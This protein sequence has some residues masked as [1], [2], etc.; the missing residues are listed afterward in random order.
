MKK[1]VVL[2]VVLIIL[3]FS[4][5]NANKAQALRICIDIPCFDEYSQNDIENS[6]N[7]FL[8]RIQKN[9]G[10]ENIEIE[11][12]PALGT[13][14]ETE[15]TRMRTEMMS[16]GGPDIF[17]IWMG[18]PDFETVF[19]ITEKSMELGAFLPLDQYIE[20]AQFMEW[21]SMTQEIFEVGRTEEGQQLIPLTYTFPATFYR[22]SEVP[23]ISSAETTWMDM[24]ED[25]NRVLTAAG[26]WGIQKN[27]DGSDFMLPSD[28]HLQNILGAVADFKNEQLLFTEDEL[29]TRMTELYSLYDL[30]SAGE[31][32]SVPWGCKRDIYVGYNIIPE[33][34]FY[35][36]LQSSDTLTMVPIYS[37]DGGVTAKVESY[38][39][40]NRNTKC[41]EDAFFV[42]DL[43]L[44]REMQLNSDLYK[45]LYFQLGSRGIPLYEDA[46]QES[47]PVYA[48]DWSDDWSMSEENYKEFCDIREQITHAYIPSALSRE[49][50]D[51]YLMWYGVQTGQ[52]TGNLKDLVSETYR[53]MDQIISE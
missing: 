4:G 45:N 36:G 48:G 17:I 1:Y 49:L 50:N 46:M 38:T 35:N 34:D 37:D 20:N 23:K 27:Y 19:P 33:L 51:L 53:T 6:I 3:L 41:P 18:T 21:N 47:A 16:G 40:I 10:P 12:L 28:S 29:Y 25:E 24:M 26:F 13:E 43:L 31:F 8:I 39:C 32:A 15:L 7:D 22:Q 52:T 11:Y 9:G 42:V 14:R 30:Y 44:S 5:C 2:T